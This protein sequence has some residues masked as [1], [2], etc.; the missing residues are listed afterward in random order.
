MPYSLR[1]MRYSVIRIELYGFVQDNSK[2]SLGFN[3]FPE[4]A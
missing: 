2:N 3:F 4:Q 1:R